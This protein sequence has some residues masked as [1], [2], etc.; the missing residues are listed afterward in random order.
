MPY[1]H[2][3]GDHQ[4]HNARALVTRGGARM[5]GDADLTTA[6]MASAIDDLL[7]D[8]AERATAA[9]DLT[10][11]LNDSARTVANWLREL[12]IRKH[13]TPEN[14]NTSEGIK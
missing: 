13:A 9:T 5:L 2:A 4:R 12:A 7:G 1:P 10:P 6:N 11:G 8:S 14:V 3:I